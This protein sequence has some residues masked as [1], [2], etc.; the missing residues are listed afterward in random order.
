MSYQSKNMDAL[1]DG[2]SVAAAAGDTATYDKNVKGF[3]DLAY[4]DMPRIPLYQPYVNVATQKSISGYQYWFHRRLDYR[5][6]VKG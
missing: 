6:L 1:I 5:A 2:A 3:V 4:A